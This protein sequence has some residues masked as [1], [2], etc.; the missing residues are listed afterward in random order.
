MWTKSACVVLAWS[1]LIILVAVGMKGPDRQAQANIRIASSTTQ[2]TLASTVSVAAVHATA[3]RPTTKYV[4]QPGDTLSGIAARF[5]VRGGW[6]ALYA[7]NRPLIGADPSVIQPG[8]VLVLPGATTPTHYTV[9]AGDTLS[10]IATEFA[11]PGGW[12]ALYAA[13]RRVVGPDPNMIQAGTVLTVRATPAPSP[14]ASSPGQPHATAPAPS[15]A[16]SGHRSPP[17]AAR[18]PGTAGMPQWLKTVLLAVALIIGTA[19]LAEPVLLAIRR[20]RLAGFGPG[21]NAA[22]AGHRTIARASTALWSGTGLRADRREE[23]PHR[24]GRL[25]PDCRDAKPG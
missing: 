3:P 14:V 11:V 17:T 20:R 24:G 16:G 5:A 6:P 7:A 1:A 18:P 12:Q 4:V 2:V 13:N 9:E 22:G 10:G 19:F 15:S 23:A 25:R 21:G 8:I